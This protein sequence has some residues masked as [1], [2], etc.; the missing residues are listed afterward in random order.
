MANTQNLDKV[1]ARL[2]VRDEKFRV[3]MHTSC[4]KE[5]VRYWRASALKEYLGYRSEESFNSCLD[6]ARIAAANSG[7]S[8]EQNFLD[9]SLFDGELDVLLTKYAAYLTVMNADP[10]KSRVALAQTFFAIQTERQNLAEE[11]R[12]ALRWEAKEAQKRLDGAAKAAGVRADRYGIFNDAG[13]RGLYGGLTTKQ[14]KAL[15]GITNDQPLLDRVDVTELAM[16]FFRITQTHDKLKRDSVN[17]EHTA[18][19]THQSVGQIVRNAVRT[20]GGEMPEN[21]PAAAKSID[22][23]AKEKL[24]ELARLDA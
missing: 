1:N 19:N 3:L 14:V 11:K 13:I 15:K 24:K 17:S 5:G 22:D 16:N 6:R 18:I 7:I 9:G 2:A 4:E 8:V 12:L 10:K 23:V 20:A 21:L